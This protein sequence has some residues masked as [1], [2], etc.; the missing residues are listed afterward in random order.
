MPPFDAH[1]SCVPS[2]PS[3]GLARSSIGGADRYNRCAIASRS[4]ACSGICLARQALGI[5]A[6]RTWLRRG[7]TRAVARQ[8]ARLDHCFG[9]TTARAAFSD[10][11]RSLAQRTDK[12]IR[13]RRARSASICANC[14]FRHVDSRAACEQ[15]GPARHQ[16]N[17]RES[18]R[19]RS[20]PSDSRSR[21]AACVIEANRH[22][23][24]CL[25]LPYGRRFQKRRLHIGC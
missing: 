5:A 16:T 14:R 8:C 18:V 13:S 20:S 11:F 1:C 22:D 10:A 6:I 7:P 17:A 4:L 3:A 2:R 24:A 23:S 12:L 15:D 19:R 9:P 25:P 21:Y